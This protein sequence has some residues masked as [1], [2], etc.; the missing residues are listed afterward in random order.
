MILFENSIIQLHYTPATD[1]LEVN[2]PDLHA[3]LLPE[4]KHSIGILVDTVKSYDIKKLLLDSTGTIQTVGHEESREITLALAKGMAQTR[5]QKVARV[6]AL[7][8]SVEALAKEN[9]QHLEQVV[10]LPFELQHFTDKTTALRWLQQERS[11]STN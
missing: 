9:I 2:Y 10:T 1:V 7:R 4:I 3:Y 11:A 5:L 6:Q 8:P